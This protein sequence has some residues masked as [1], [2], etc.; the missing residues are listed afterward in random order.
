MILDLIAPLAA[1]VAIFQ[2]HRNGPVL[3]GDLSSFHGG[4]S[5]CVK[6]EEQSCRIEPQR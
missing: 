1:E 4:D 5:L 6:T 3:V 2:F